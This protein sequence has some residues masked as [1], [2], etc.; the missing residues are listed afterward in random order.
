VD[1]NYGEEVM[2]DWQPQIVRIEKVEP[3]S[4]ADTLDIATVLGD[5]P[6]IVKRGEYKPGDLVGY[7]PI[8]SI[9]PDTEQFY[10]LCPKSYEKYEDENGQLQ[11]R[12]LGPKYPV[13]SVPEKNRIIKAKKIRGVYSMGMLDRVGSWLNDP[14]DTGPAGGCQMSGIKYPY[15][16]GDSI[17]EYLGLKKWEE[18][19][20]DNLPTIKSRGANQASAPKGWSIPHYDIE[21]VRKY[22]SCVEGEQD[23]ILTEKLHGS[24]AGFCHDGEQLVVKSRNFY[25]KRDQDD[26][27]WEA[28]L[29]YDL[30]TKLAKYHLLVFFAE[31]IGNIKKFRYNAEL[32]DGKLLT[33]LYFFDIWDTKT[34][35]YL[36]YDRFV[37]VCADV[38]VETTP[39]LYRGPWLDTKAMYAYAERQT[40]LGGKHI[41]EGWVL[42]LGKERFEPRLNS[43]LKLKYVS[44]AYN[45]QK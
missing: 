28:A 31:C 21:S 44:E 15:E 3:H 23:V 20:E 6:V 1:Q 42:S 18:E 24:N 32:V 7:I 2:S 14:N 13:G 11:Q 19:E 39:L 9:V 25:K 27:W 45:L 30:E 12:Q 10:F 35:R 22:L 34:M 38:G 17:V 36:D 40:T 5:Y 29:R 26:M 16:V 4:D 43:R 8:D 41:A 37:E 33:K